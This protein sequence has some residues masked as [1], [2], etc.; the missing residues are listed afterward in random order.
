MPNEF[1]RLSADEIQHFACD[2]KSVIK[3]DLDVRKNLFS[4]YGSAHYSNLS[5]TVKETVNLYMEYR[6]VLQVAQRRG[7]AESTIYK[8][9]FK[10]GVLNPHEFISELELNRI[11]YLREINAEDR[12]QEI[13]RILSSTAKKSAFYYLKDLEK[14]R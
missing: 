5:N 1:N 6:D 12:E 4:S 13:E 14:Q 3:N 10:G 7:F 8:H 11:Q 9:L 2:K